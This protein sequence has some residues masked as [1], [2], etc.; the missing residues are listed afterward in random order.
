MGPQTDSLAP[1]DLAAI[2]P[3]FEVYTYDGKLGE[4]EEVLI[5]TPEEGGSYLLIK[6]GWFSK[7]Y[8]LPAT[9]IKSVDPPVVTLRGHEDELK[10]FMTE[11]R[12]AAFRMAA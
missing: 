1:L 3:G 4:V 5:G 2:Q 12:P 7:N 8:Y 11:T 6:R 9:L 10:R